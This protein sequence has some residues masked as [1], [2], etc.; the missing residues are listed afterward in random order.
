MWGECGRVDTFAWRCPQL[1]LDVFLR[2]RLF[3]SGVGVVGVRGLQRE[4][5]REGV[6]FVAGLSGFP[7]YF[8]LHFV[9]CSL[10][11]VVLF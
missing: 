6:W 11:L 8:F 7:H 3:H 5:L 4:Y 9:I 1:R 2:Y 10:L